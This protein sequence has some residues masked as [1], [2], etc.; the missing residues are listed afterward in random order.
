MPASAKSSFPRKKAAAFEPR[1]AETSSAI[2]HKNDTP[3]PP[4]RGKTPRSQC[5]KSE[6]RPISRQSLKANLGFEGHW[7]LR[8]PVWPGSREPNRPRNCS[9]FLNRHSGRRFEDR[10]ET[11][12]RRTTGFLRQAYR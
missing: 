3:S 7:K 8:T 5:P 1:G 11:F 4:N 2:S 9:E 12:S 6:V 10:S